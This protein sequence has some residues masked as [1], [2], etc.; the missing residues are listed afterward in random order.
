MTRKCVVNYWQLM[1]VIFVT[2]YLKATCILNDTFRFPKDEVE[3][4]KWLSAIR[5]APDFE[6]S[7]HHYICSVHFASGDFTRSHHAPYHL[8]KRHSVPSKFPWTYQPDSIN[9]A[10]QIDHSYAAE[11]CLPHTDH[12]YASSLENKLES[13][14]RQIAEQTSGSDFGDSEVAHYQ[15]LVSVLNFHNTSPIICP[16]GF[17]PARFRPG[18]NLWMSHI[19]ARSRFTLQALQHLKEMQQQ[20][21]WK[22]SRCSLMLDA[23]S[24]RKNLVW[25]SKSHKMIGFV[26]YGTGAE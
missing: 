12:S 14:S 3:R 22:Y 16:S 9:E 23:M 17:W 6:P 20:D 26:D 1:H 24:L 11:R 2:S 13:H 19:D 8:L 21:E 5:A 7:N 18:S 15:L 4:K 10:Y 25:D